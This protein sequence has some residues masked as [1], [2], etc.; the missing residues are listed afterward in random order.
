MCTKTLGDICLKNE[1]PQTK[2]RKENT[3]EKYPIVDLIKKVAVFAPIVPPQ[4]LISAVSLLV[5]KNPVKFASSLLSNDIMLSNKK[6]ESSTKRI[7]TIFFFLS[8]EMLK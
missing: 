7:P 1:M 3:K 6:T 2:R 4:L 5:V 8:E